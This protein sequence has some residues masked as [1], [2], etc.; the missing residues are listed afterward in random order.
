[1]ASS[2]NATTGTARTCID[3]NGDVILQLGKEDNSNG[4]LLV[5]SRALAQGSRAFKAMF[6]DKWSGEMPTAAS[7]QTVQLPDDNLD[8]VILLCLVLHHRSSDIPDHLTCAELADFTLLCDKYDCIGAARGW[9]RSWVLDLVS[10]IEKKDCSEKLILV[11]YVFDLPHE[12]YKVTQ[13]LLREKTFN[14]RLGVATHGH[15]LI[16]MEVFDRLRSAELNYHEGIRGALSFNHLSGLCTCGGNLPQLLNWYTIIEG[17]GGCDSSLCPMYG[18]LCLEFT[19]A[20]AE[21]GL[22]PIKI[23]TLRGY[24]DLLSE[25]PDFQVELC[26]SPEGCL[27]SSV[28]LLRRCMKEQVDEVIASVNGICLDCIYTE[29][30]GKAR[31]C[32]AGAHN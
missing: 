19:T 20:M 25:M 13:A 1:M 18:A 6:S 31:D 11:A 10:R 14:V 5:S 17:Y 16:P 21:N 32:R 30:D 24:Q 27:C 7:P 9:V 28:L 2:N 12:F 8:L 26:D 15:H 23:N 3:D 29:E 4:A 22:F